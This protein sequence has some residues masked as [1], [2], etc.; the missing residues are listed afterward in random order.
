MR[1]KR[2]DNE[3]SRARESDHL[4]REEK[5]S[6]LA[7]I[8]PTSPALVCRSL[9]SLS[10]SLFFSARTS[11]MRC[12]LVA[13]SERVLSYSSLVEREVS[14]ALINP[15]K[16]PTTPRKRF[17]SFSSNGVV[18]A[19]EEDDEDNEVEEEGKGERGRVIEGGKRVAREVPM[20]EMVV[21]EE[22]EEGRG[23]CGL[24]G[25]DDGVVV[26]VVVEVSAVSILLEASITPTISPLWSVSGA[27]M[28]LRVMAPFRSSISRLKRRSR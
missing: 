2:E 13:F 14:S 12:V 8:S 16:R 26:V 15:P 5:W 1:W 27:H 9:V 22:D 10:T 17:T 20:A 7:L 19:V 11:Y 6:I 21:M 18:L 24:A 25:N 4:K 28:T 23:G 3:F